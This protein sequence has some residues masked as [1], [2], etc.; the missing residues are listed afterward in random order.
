MVDA[1]KN[2]FG[3]L[4]VDW[5]LL[6]RYPSEECINKVS[7]PVMHIHGD[8]DRVVPIGLGRKLFEHVPETST[9]GVKRK[10]IE[11]PGAGHNNILQ[12]IPGRYRE[13]VLLFLERA[14]PLP[15]PGRL[16]G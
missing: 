2:R 8:S 6:D 12:V 16:A 14:C 7:C 11:L 3:W 1:A 9:H 15:V 5:L 13:A 10:F 4:P